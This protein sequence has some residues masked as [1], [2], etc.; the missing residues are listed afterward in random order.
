MSTHQAEKD[1]KEI[2]DLQSQV[3]TTRS[4]LE[5]CERRNLALFERFEK[6]RDEWGQIAEHIKNIQLAG[7]NKVA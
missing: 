4:L 1:D 7:I 5:K 6:L 3:N 2:A